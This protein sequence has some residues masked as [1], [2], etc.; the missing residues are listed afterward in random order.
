DGAGAGA[1]LRSGRSFGD[2]DRCTRP[3]FRY[4]CRGRLSR[5]PGHGHGETRRSRGAQRAPGFVM[6]SGSGR[7]ALPPASSGL[8]ALSATEIIDGYQRRAFTPRDVV[9]DAIT[10][11][12]TTDAVCNVVVTAMYEQACA[13]ADRLTAAMRSG[14]ATGPLAG[15][16]ITVKDLVFVAGVPAF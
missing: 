7:M 12:K 9:D 1:K 6:N 5:P 11:L 8:A 14:E 3:Y 10:A 15:V 2:Q 13:E 16:P 4:P